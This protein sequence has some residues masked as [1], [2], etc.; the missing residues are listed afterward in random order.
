MDG[1]GADWRS[2]SLL[3]HRKENEHAG[4]VAGLLGQVAFAGSGAGEVK[5]SRNRAT[6]VKNVARASGLHGDDRE[7]TTS[8]REIHPDDS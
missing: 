1:D 7:S 5:Q 8:G 4:A 2:G 3:N 6:A